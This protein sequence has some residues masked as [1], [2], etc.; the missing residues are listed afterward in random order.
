MHPAL[1][2]SKKRQ[3]PYR[4]LGAGLLGEGVVSRSASG[5]ANFYQM[6]LAMLAPRAILLNA[7]GRWR[8]RGG[9]VR[10]HA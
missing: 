9:V 3:V 5:T 1:L 2:L 6:V 8:G 10:G 4:L 7:Q